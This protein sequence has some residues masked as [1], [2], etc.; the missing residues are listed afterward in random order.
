[1]GSGPSSLGLGRA[2]RRTVKRVGDGN[3]LTEEMDDWEAT[4]RYYYDGWRRVEVRDGSSRVDRPAAGWAELRG[5]DQRSDRPR[6]GRRR[7]QAG[8]GRERNRL[9]VTRYQ[10][11]RPFG[12]MAKE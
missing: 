11:E 5:T 8:S 2:S 9:C 6:L 1:M 3:A 12:A 7:N 10:I 4:Y